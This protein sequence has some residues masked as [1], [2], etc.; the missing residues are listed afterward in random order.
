MTFPVYVEF[1]LS[2][3]IRSAELATKIIYWVDL[4][5]NE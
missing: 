3:P 4:A 5:S 1:V 2:L